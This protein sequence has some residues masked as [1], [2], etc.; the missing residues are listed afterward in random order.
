MYL[1]IFCICYEYFN[2]CKKKKDNWKQTFFYRHNWTFEIQI[3]INQILYNVYIT[4]ICSKY[5]NNEYF[6]KKLLYF[7]F[8]KYFFDFFVVVIYFHLLF[9][10]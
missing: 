3:N 8:V 2:I 4:Y 6:K 5:L 9:Y 1:W 10:F 7:F